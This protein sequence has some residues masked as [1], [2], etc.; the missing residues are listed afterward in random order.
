MI[1]QSRAGGE[2]IP[3]E[4]G[5][6]TLHPSF[7]Q[8]RVKAFELHCHH[9]TLGPLGARV[10]S[11]QLPTVTVSAEKAFPGAGLK[12]FYMDGQGSF[13]KNPG[14]CQN[15]T[16]HQ[17]EKLRRGGG[18]MSSSVASVPRLCF[19]VMQWLVFQV[20]LQT[21]AKIMQIANNEWEKCMYI[22][23]YFLHRFHL[24][25]FPLWCFVKA[26]SKVTQPEYYLQFYL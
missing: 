3:L 26:F 13:H 2:E 23:L 6:A 22:L 10:A 14:Q 24:C 9:K 8:I 21:L 20:C 17:Q 12:L 4:G 15:C 5:T 18:V 19:A 1:V 11:S 7:S 16:L 25:L